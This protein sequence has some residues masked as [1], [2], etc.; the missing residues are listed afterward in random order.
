MNLTI[1]TAVWKRPE[2]FEVF[3]DGITNLQESFK[4][5]LKI[6]V[7]VA[8]SEGEQSRN[9]VESRGYAYIEIDNRALGM[10]MNRAA[11]LAQGQ[12][13]DYCLLVG[14]DDI[15]GVD[16]LELYYTE[17][18]NGTDYIYVTDF[19]FFD[20]QSKKAL[21]WGGYTKNTNRG[22]ACGA[23]RMLSRPVMNALKFQPWYDNQMHNILDTAF[24]RKIRP[25]QMT[26]KAFNLKQNGCFGLDIKSS[27][28]MTP[29][30]P[31]AGTVEVDAKEMLNNLPIELARKI[32]GAPIPCPHCGTL[33]KMFGI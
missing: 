21:Y 13:P 32:Y 2:I 18:L 29:F 26:K 8:G 10:K 15:I 31:W 23:G 16:M 4:G 28:N 3:A 5:R 20:T 6:S 11:M 14:S 22:H 9:M 12:D 1:V 33:L 25:I 24:D 17:M 19:Y 7:T 30:A 27:T